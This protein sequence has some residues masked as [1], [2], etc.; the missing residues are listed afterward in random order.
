MGGMV[1]VQIDEVDCDGHTSRLV[2]FTGTGDLDAT[3]EFQQWLGERV[4]AQIMAD[5]PV[6]TTTHTDD[7]GMSNG[8]VWWHTD[9][10]N[11]SFDWQHEV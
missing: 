3:E 5:N 6:H 9:E 7:R 11:I 4:V 10:G 2:M 1:E 8:V